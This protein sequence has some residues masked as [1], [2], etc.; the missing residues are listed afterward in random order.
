[1]AQPCPMDQL[2]EPGLLAVIGVVL[3]TVPLP[4]HAH[5]VDRLQEICARV[6][7]ATAPLATSAEVLQ[8]VATGLDLTMDNPRQ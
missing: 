6:L 4:G 7:E 5:N 3:E 2:I 8:R 1:M